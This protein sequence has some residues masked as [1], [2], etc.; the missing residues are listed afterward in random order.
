MGF[1]GAVVSLEKVGKLLLWNGF[2][3]VFDGQAHLVFLLSECHFYIAV[4]CRMGH[5][6]V[7][8][9]MRKLCD[10][11][12]IASSRIYPNHLL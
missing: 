5:G 4:V 7:N 3:V 1:I 9:D 10:P 6:I 8:E 12:F 2:A 11:L